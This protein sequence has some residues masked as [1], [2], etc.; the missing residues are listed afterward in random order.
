MVSFAEKLN[1][2]SKRQALA[3]L[4][5]VTLFICLPLVNASLG[6]FKQGECVNIKTILNA[7]QVNISSI[8]NPDSAVVMTEGIMTKIGYTFNYT[9]CN[10]T[11]LGTYIYDYYDNG[12]NVY[13][14]DF[15]ITPTG[16]ESSN[17]QGLMILAQIGIVGLFFGL[18]FSFSKEKWK[19]RTFFFVSSLF[20]GIVTLNSLRVVAGSSSVLSSMS[21]LGLILG[22][23]LI[24]F[25]ILYIMIN[26]TVEI[27]KFYKEKKRMRWE[28]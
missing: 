24:S 27:I 5:A 10:T 9:Y 6:T 2:F 23:S 21:N 19:I 12:G 25:M 22:I 14:N 7:S 11:Q 15:E 28:V 16:N 3:L 17:T 18:G 26:Y 8:S 20:M 4:L 1:E 13:V